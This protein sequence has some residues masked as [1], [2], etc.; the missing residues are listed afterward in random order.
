MLRNFF[1]K[2]EKMQGKDNVIAA[3]GDA[4]DDADRATSRNERAMSNLFMYDHTRAVIYVTI[5]T[6][7]EAGA[8]LGEAASELSSEFERNDNHIHAE[9]IRLFFGAVASGS[10]EEIDVRKLA[11]RA[12]GKNF[13][14]PEEV[15]LLRR[16]LN[17]DKAEKVLRGAAQV[18]AMKSGKSSGHTVAIAASAF[19]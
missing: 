19:S 18:A 4:S 8:T 16:L 17:T 1:C 6:L 15:A 12:F 9:I 5:A 13:V 11:D 7:V 3:F 14:S 10:A 2:V